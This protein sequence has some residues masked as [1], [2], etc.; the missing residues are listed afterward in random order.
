M[1][2]SAML[3][4]FLTGLRSK[5]EEV[6]VKSVHELHHYVSTELREMPMEVHTTFMDEFNHSVLE[7]LSSS[8]MNERKGGIL[9]IGEL[10]ISR[11]VTQLCIGLD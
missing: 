4:Q 10:F 3:S 8:D 7:M 1:S 6:R 2:S 9:A 11:S 5:T